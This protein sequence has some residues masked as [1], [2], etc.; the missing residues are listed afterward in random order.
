MK[1][2]WKRAR[3]TPTPFGET[4][5]HAC[6]ACD[7]D[8]RYSQLNQWIYLG[9]LPLFPYKNI[10]SFYKC[11][12][13]GSTYRKTIRDYMVI[14]P[15]KKAEYKHSLQ[16]LFA[17]TLVAC[18]TY[19]AVIDEGMARKEKKKLREIID[20]VQGLADVHAVANRILNSED[21]SKEEV[22]S[23]LRQA[24]QQLTHEAIILLLARVAEMLLADGEISAEEKRLMHRF[25]GVAGLSDSLY[26]T[27][28][29]QARTLTV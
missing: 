5:P 28:L 23:L 20:E 6:P 3:T 4:L 7:S 13:C 16:E 18:A 22:F 25:L 9:S 8:V 17:L 27:V 11:V 21:K 24:T 15:E 29:L 19:M 12:N 26:E 14:D 1:F 10:D 2:L